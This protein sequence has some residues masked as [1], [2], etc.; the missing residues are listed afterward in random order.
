MNRITLTFENG[1]G[2]KG[3]DDVL[4]AVSKFASSHMGIDIKVY[5]RNSVYSFGTH[6]D[7]TPEGLV[8]DTSK[9]W[10]KDIYSE[11]HKNDPTPTAQRQVQRTS[12]SKVSLDEIF[13]SV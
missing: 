7:I 11:I 3:I 6:F 5:D 13:R 2:A 10:N 12:E 1:G 9:Y 8:E 4:E